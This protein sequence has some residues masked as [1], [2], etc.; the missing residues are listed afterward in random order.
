[1]GGVLSDCNDWSKVLTSLTESINKDLNEAFPNIISEGCTLRNALVEIKSQTN[2]RFIF[3]IDEWDCIYR[4]E[5][6]NTKLCDE[7]TNF[8]RSLF[9][10]SI[11]SSCIDLVYM[12]GILPIRRY[13]ADST[14]NN[15]TEYNMI[16]HYPL[17]KFMGFTE[18]E[19]IDLCNKY[20]MPFEDLK[21]WYNG[22]YLEGVGSIYNPKSVVEAIYEEECR[23]YWTQTRSMDDIKNYMNYDNGVLKSDI[24]S[25]LA[26]DKVKVDVV[27]FE[28]D[29]TKINSRDAAL[30]VLIHLGYL[31]Y[32]EEYK[33]CYIPNYEIKQELQRAIEDLDWEEFKYPI[34]ASSDLIKATF[35]LNFDY[36]NE[37]FDKN[38]K[39]LSTIFNKNK[40]DI[41]GVVTYLSYSQM[42]D[43]YYVNKEANTSTGRCDIIYKPRYKDPAMIVELKVDSTPSDAIKQINNKHYLDLLGSYKGEV[44]LVGINYNSKT[45]KHDSMVEVVNK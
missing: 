45:L 36:I 23:D 42:N 5:A 39:E 22:Y 32:D 3:L 35:N 18:S 33:S 15:F 43:R 30:T 2:E 6:Y 40:E 13:N 8:L 29:L 9:K 19:V 38:H 1:M 7:Y 25:M 12:T 17:G 34:E 21:N 24:A 20:D 41:L 27:K 44:Y 14:L 11:C 28:N 4:E 31:A 10:D 37:V 16:N 26:G